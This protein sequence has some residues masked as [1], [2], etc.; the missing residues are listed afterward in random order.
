MT[1]VPT[2]DASGDDRLAIYLA[3]HRA[4]A[5]GG[6]HLARRCAEANPDNE[7]GRYLRDVL[8][9]AIELD[10][11]I[12]DDVMRAAGA[13]RSPVKDLS[14][15]IGVALGGLKPNGQLT[16]YSPL[17][18]VIELEAL[19]AGVVAKRSLW[20]TVDRVRDQLGRSELPD[21]AD[22]ID[23]ADQQLAGLRELHQAA[24]RQAF[25]AGTD[26]AAG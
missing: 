9:P 23:A 3:D 7:V 8:L 13:R 4:A 2:T 10:Q 21:V 11:R 14:A 18:R 26:A 15:R 17:S 20:I 5:L 25:G 6:E 12:L 22:R 16:G 19:I 24:V 1:T